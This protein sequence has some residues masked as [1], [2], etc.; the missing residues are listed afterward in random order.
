MELIGQF[1]DVKNKNKLVQ[2]NIQVFINGNDSLAFYYDSYSTL[3]CAVSINELK[4]LELYF[5]PSDV[6]VIKGMWNSYNREN[7][8]TN[9]LEGCL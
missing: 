1:K 7:K 2:R 9:I 5:G 3:I 4:K 8:L 6:N